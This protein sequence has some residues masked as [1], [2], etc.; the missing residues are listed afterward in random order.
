VKAGLKIKERE[1]LFDNYKYLAVLIQ[2]LIGFHWRPSTPDNFT[3]RYA[4]SG[5]RQH[6]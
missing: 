5:L 3:S 6:D 4:K 2:N 1:V